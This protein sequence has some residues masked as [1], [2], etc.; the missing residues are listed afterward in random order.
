MIAYADCISHGSTL[1]EYD[2]RHDTATLIKTWGM[3]S[4]I[5]SIS[6]YERMMNHI[7][8]TS[9]IRPSN[10]KKL[11]NTIIR[12]EASPTPDETN[13]WTEN[14]W[15]A[16]ADRLL[17]AMDYAE[18]K[19]KHKNFRHTN[20]KNTMGAAYLHKDS[21]SGIYHLHFFM[22]RV[23]DEGHANCG[24]H[25]GELA[26][27]AA[28]VINKERGW[29]LPES[30]HEAHVK[31]VT[32]MC[33][34]ILRGMKTFCLED[35]LDRIRTKGFVVKTRLS[36]D[37]IVGYTIMYGN[38]PLNA[39]KLADKH[40]LTVANIE[41]T[42]AKLHG[43]TPMEVSVIG[44]GGERIDTKIIWRP[45]HA[46]KPK[47]QVPVDR[48]ANDTEVEIKRP[49]QNCTDKIVTVGNIDY[50]IN[51][52]NSIVD[53]IKSD[54]EE[55]LEDTALTVEKMIDVAV[56]LVGGYVDA[57]TRII[58]SSAGGGGNN[59]LPKRKKDE[60]DEQWARRCTAFVLNRCKKP[61]YRMKR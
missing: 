38:S 44:T 9:H 12:I 22:C 21:K 30:I 50:N 48:T 43:M 20:L 57:A 45:V 53:I 5:T 52:A 13:G 1:V 34:N 46:E 36:N 51:I 58:P 41:K 40:T 54:I 56:L 35:Y 31:E 6:M 7:A 32:D 25:L 26:V 4:D 60:E 29:I 27:A 17:A 61:K 8:A 24:N 42:W 18:P 37:K 33:Y 15:A 19:S 59:D 2:S 47:V 39:S 16:L 11:K 10:H 3:P 49:V 28:D 23:D 55:S 14:D